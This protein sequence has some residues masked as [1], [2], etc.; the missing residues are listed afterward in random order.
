MFVQWHSRARTTIPT[1]TR[2]CSRLVKAIADEGSMTAAAD[3]LGYSQP[4]VSQQLKRAEA[5]L[6]LALVERVGRGVRLTEAGSRPRAP[7]SVGHVGAGCRRRRARRTPWSAVRARAARGLPV[8]VAHDRAE[9]ARRPRGAASGDHRH[10]CR[11][12][13]ARGGA[14][15][16][17]RPRRHRSDVQ[18]SGRPR[19]SARR[20][21]P[22]ACRCASWGQTTCSPCFRGVTPP[23]G[24][25]SWMSRS[26]PTRTGS[27][28]ARA[29]GATCWSSADARA[30]SRGSRSR[31]TTS[32]PSRGLSPR[33]SAS[34][35]C[36][37][38]AVESFPQL[39]GVVTRP[40]PGGRAAHAP[41]R[42][43]ASRRARPPVRAHAGCDRA[44]APLTG[45][46]GIPQLEWAGC[47]PHPIP[48]PRARPAPTCASASAPRRPAFRTSA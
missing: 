13:T 37:R 35:R 40:L 39:P 6:G 30:S 34:R 9:A 42:D 8:G 23:R 17:G 11:G 36:P 10:V 43:R 18:L 4:A 48:A 33:A 28:D 47:L 46:R 27:R 3:A 38:L 25:A 12:R 5:R 7:R 19:R 22:A 31:P 14:G 1:S 45:G 20:R 26:S 2:S 41:R 29:A 21:A 16:A 24:R 32:S 44:G 15:R